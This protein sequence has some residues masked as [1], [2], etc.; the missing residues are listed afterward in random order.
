MI[1][2]SESTP[3]P[4]G[5][6]MATYA[7]YK[8]LGGLGGIVSTLSLTIPSIV[9]III[10]AKFMEGFQDNKSVKA[11]F[12]GSFDPPTNG[13]L[14]IINR[15]YRIFDSVDVVVSVNPQ[16]KYMF[17]EEER[18]AMLTELTKKYPNVRVNVCKEL[19]VN[20]AKKT[21]ASVLIRGIR[22]TN[23]FS[24]EFDLA[25]MN[26]NLNPDI[27]TL[28]C[29]EMKIPAGYSE[30]SY[31]QLEVIDNG[32]ES[33]VSDF[34]TDEFKIIEKAINMNFKDVIACPYIPTGAS[35][36]RFISRVCDNCY[37]FAPFTISDEQLEGIHGLNE[38]INLS[39]LIP[40][41]EFYK[42]VIKESNNGK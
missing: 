14:D 26:Q 10:I 33:I 8:T 39:C 36:S 20:Y 9:I 38:N 42:T 30:K 13:H 35:D 25:H 6:N 5:L 17:S 7:G 22:S 31:I 11:V 19:I 41:V 37:R 15:T 4:V 18:V 12:A 2:I 1:A 32:I 29:Q 27:E 16:K 3:G 40:A 24:Y 21:G 23:D 28:E 34:K